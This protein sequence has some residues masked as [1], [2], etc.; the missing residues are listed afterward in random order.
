M[1]QNDVQSLK[2]RVKLLEDDNDALRNDVDALKS[3]FKEISRTRSSLT[4]LQ[5][6]MSDMYYDLNNKV[7][8]V[9]GM[10]AKSTQSM[11][12]SSGYPP[13]ALPSHALV[14]IDPKIE[15]LVEVGQLT[16]KQADQVYQSKALM[17]VFDNIGGAGSTPQKDVQSG[18]H[19]TALTPAE[20]KQ[21]EKMK[22]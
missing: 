18:R 9:R 3:Q 16:R 6:D 11:T 8:S 1:A 10:M 14:D 7:A 17:Q 5:S 2:D 21:R 22:K 20:I 4:Q 13:A 12:R 19:D 15:Q